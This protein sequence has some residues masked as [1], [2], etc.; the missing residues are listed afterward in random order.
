MC[1]KSA[2]NLWWL[3]ANMPGV[4][5]VGAGWGPAEEEAC[6]AH[7][8][9]TKGL[10]CLAIL[11]TLYPVVPLT[12]CNCSDVAPSDPL[13]YY[14]CELLIVEILQRMCADKR[15]TSCSKRQ[16][17]KANKIASTVFGL[18]MFKTIFVPATGV[19]VSMLNHVTHFWMKATLLMGAEGVELPWTYSTLTV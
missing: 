19:F 10:L 1:E 7:S 15:N 8:S 6:T 3:C 4:S 18:K 16:M 11:Q 17:I 13:T 2:S 9:P 5:C 14:Q 12:C